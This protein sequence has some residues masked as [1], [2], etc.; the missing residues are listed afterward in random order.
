MRPV[1]CAITD[2]RLTSVDHAGLWLARVAAAAA[3]GAHL[4]QVRE[5]GLD[6]RAL[7]ALVRRCRE[8]VR[9]TSARVVVNDR[10][11]VA[12]ACGADGVHLRSESYPAR[13]A[14][15]IVPRGFLVG[16]SIHTVAEAE[17]VGDSADYLIFGTVFATSSKPGQTPV[18]PAA[19]AAAVLATPVPV[20]AVGGVTADTA[21]AVARAGAAGIAAIGTFAGGT[22]GDVAAS[23]D[24]I[25]RAFDL[26]MS[27]S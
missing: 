17:A 27:G 25:V 18:G 24:R 1:F 7:S 21:G 26:A 23:V 8:V 5:R 13:R 2:G 4:I 11:D 6:D 14:R 22:P 15:E 20:L 10:L 3:A 19:L 12:L 9:G 16:R